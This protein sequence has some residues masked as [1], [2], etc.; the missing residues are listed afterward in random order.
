M[1]IE[2]FGLLFFVVSVDLHHVGP[3]LS[4][5]VCRCHM[6]LHVSIF[7]GRTAFP[8]RLLTRVGLCKFVSS[9]LT[10]RLIERSPTEVK[11]HIPREIL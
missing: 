3:M 5:V 10:S 8:L 9:K 1:I 2:C 7:P 4:R 6:F 11:R